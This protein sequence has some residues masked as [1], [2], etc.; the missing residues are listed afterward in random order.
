LV[1]SLFVRK[2]LPQG[3]HAAAGGIVGD[4]VSALDRIEQ[5]ARQ[6]CDLG[7]IG[8]GVDRRHTADVL[9]HA[10][11]HASALRVISAQS[12]SWP[13]Q[14]S[15]IAELARACVVHLGNLA[16]AARRAEW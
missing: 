7:G 5:S 11:G 14:S 10:R 1:A 16:C 13:A 6:G 12:R 9:A 2:N 3:G 8:R 15:P 4:K